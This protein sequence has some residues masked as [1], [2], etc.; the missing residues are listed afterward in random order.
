MKI[1]VFTCGIVKTRQD[2]KG[3]GITIPALRGS[4]RT[5]LNLEG[6]RVRRFHPKSNKQRLCF[7]KTGCLEVVFLLYAFAEK[8]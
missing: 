4:Q 3:L 6:A 2:R 1:V 7:F 5:H 8:T